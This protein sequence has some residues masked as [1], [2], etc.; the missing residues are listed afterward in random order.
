VFPFLKSL[1]GTFVFA[2]V[3]NKSAEKGLGK[4]GSVFAAA[5]P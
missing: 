3:Q 1:S 4:R 2:K 5:T